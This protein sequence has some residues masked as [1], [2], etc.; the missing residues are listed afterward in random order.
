MIR[1]LYTAAAG[2]MTNIIRQQANT[3]NLANVATIGYKEDSTVY[4]PA[5]EMAI[6]DPT[7]ARPRILG[8]LATG[9]EVSGVETN[10]APGSLKETNNP[11]DFA[12]DGEGFFTV[13]SETGQRYYTRNGAWDRDATGRLVTS[14]GELVLGEHGP[15]QLPEGQV[16]VAGDGSISVDGQFVDRLQ[17]STFPDGTVIQKVG[18]T[19]FEPTDANIQ[20]VAAQNVTVMQG[21]VETSNVDEVRAMVEMMSALR[22]YEAEQRTLQ[23]QDQALG[24]AVSELGKV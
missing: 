17:L 13:Q 19:L 21:Y 6:G 11:F 15:I 1:G 10:L 24:L 8:P 9:I 2:M 5:P 7:A 20:P 12:L 4:T 16:V 14:T 3:N 18:N 23:I 22:A